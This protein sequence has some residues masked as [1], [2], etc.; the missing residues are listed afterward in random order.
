MDAA[1]SA[2]ATGA[3]TPPPVLLHDRSRGSLRPRPD[4]AATQGAFSTLQA[5]TT[6]TRPSH[7]LPR[8]HKLPPLILLFNA[9]TCLQWLPRRRLQHN[10]TSLQRQTSR[11]PHAYT[12]LLW[13]L[14]PSACCNTTALPGEPAFYSTRAAAALQAWSRLRQASSPCRHDPDEPPGA[15]TGG[16]APGVRSRGLTAH[17]SSAAAGSSSQHH[18]Y[19]KPAC[20]ESPHCCQRVAKGKRPREG[21]P[22]VDE[23]TGHS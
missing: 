20:E 10:R 15:N 13:I 4:L 5:A 21:S 22:G 9:G 14:R 3:G 18:H 12:Q 1:G 8:P 11:Q 23:E 17:D 6:M 2:A 7:Q 16:S 19:S